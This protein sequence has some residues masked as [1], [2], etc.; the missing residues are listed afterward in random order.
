MAQVGGGESDVSFV[1]AIECPICQFL[2]TGKRLPVFHLLETTKNIS[3]QLAVGSD[4]EIGVN[5]SKCEP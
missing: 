2:S 1:A 3:G 5:D 4:G